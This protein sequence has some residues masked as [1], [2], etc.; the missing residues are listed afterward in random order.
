LDA[1]TPYEALGGRTPTER[2]EELKRQKA[3]YRELTGLLPNAQASLSPEEWVNFSDRMK[4]Y[5]EV[6]AMRWLQQRL[7]N[8]TAR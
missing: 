3:E 7:A 8:A 5:G 4:A 2:L 1:T 6:A